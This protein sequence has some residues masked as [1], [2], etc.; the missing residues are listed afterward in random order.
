MATPIFLYGSETWV[1]NTSDQ[2]KIH[3]SEI[4]FLRSVTGCTCTRLD[5]L[6]ND[7]IRCDLN[8]YNTN[9][10]IK[11]YQY[12]WKKHVERMDNDKLLLEYKPVGHRNRGHPYT[13]WLI[14]GARTG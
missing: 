14:I 5:H 2:S 1:I 8:N 11:D 6:T 7:S 12:A 4:K 13:V 10:V 3:A 9:Y